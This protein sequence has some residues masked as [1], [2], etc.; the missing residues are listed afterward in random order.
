MKFETKRH[1][2]HQAIYHVDFKNYKSA[3]EAGT[4]L[5]LT[6]LDDWT[7]NGSLVSTND[8]EVAFKLRVHFENDI[9]V[10]RRSQP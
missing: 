3:C 1:K 2:P 5:K 8:L 4:W 7:A 9:K 10:I 6:G